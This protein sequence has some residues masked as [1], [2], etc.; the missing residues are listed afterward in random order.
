LCSI[1]ELPVGFH[2]SAASLPKKAA[3]SADTLG[4][5]IMLAMLFLVHPKDGLACQG[6][7]AFLS[8]VHILTTAVLETHGR[9]GGADR[10]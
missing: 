1:A 10:E 7:Q 2:Q 6:G 5:E 4:A 8:D 9:S 3:S